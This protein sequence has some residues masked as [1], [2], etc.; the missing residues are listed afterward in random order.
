MNPRSLFIFAGILLILF[1]GCESKS[2]NSADAISPSKQIVENTSQGSKENPS[3]VVPENSFEFPPVV[4]GVEVVHDY[5][6]LNKGDSDL[7]IVRVKT[8]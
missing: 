3:I 6:V 7:E 1:A 5:K 8:G 4:E 2:A